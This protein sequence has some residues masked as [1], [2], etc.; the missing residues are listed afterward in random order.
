MWTQVGIF[1]SYSYHVLAVPYFWPIAGPK[2]RGSLR[3]VVSGILGAREATGA[4]HNLC[5]A[6]T[7]TRR[8]LK[9]IS[10]FCYL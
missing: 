8:D 6:R 3:P 5:L 2:G 9:I 10:N 7:L 1:L 4:T